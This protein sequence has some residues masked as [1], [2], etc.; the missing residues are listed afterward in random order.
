MC[1]GRCTNWLAMRSLLV[2]EILTIFAY[3]PLVAPE[4]SAMG[5]TH[6]GLSQVPQGHAQCMAFAGLL[7]A[8]TPVAACA[9]GSGGHR[10]YANIALAGYE[11]ALA[12]RKR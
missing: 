11:D 7:C 10:T 2:A 6:A 4:R 9:I 3:K 12:A 1:A 5:A 8:A